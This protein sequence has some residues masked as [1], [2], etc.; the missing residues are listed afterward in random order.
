MSELLRVR[1]DLP[2]GFLSAEIEALQDLLGGPTLIH[3]KGRRDDTL[4][5]STLLHGNEDTGFKA[6]Q[7]LLQKH[8]LN[9]LPRN[10]SIFIGNVAAAKL[11]MR[12]LDGQP[13]Y[14]RVWP[15]AADGG[16]PE[17]ALMHAVVEHMR[18]RNL[19][20]SVDIHNN[21]GLNPHYAC[22]N[23][24]EQPF[25]HLATLFSRTVVYFLRPL[26]VQS[27]AF[28]PLCP[29]VTLECGKPGS[30]D[31][32]THAL[33]FLD[34]CLHLTALPTHA[35]AK[36]DLDLFHTVATVKVAEN[37]EF[38][39]G[40]GPGALRLDP[41]LDH[42]NFCELPPGTRFGQLA[43]D[44]LDCLEVRDEMGQAVGTRYFSAHQGELTTRRPIMP[45]ML[46]RDER[47]IRQDCLCYLMERLAYE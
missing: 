46:T 31:S 16:T 38:G 23:R 18:T 27:S 7:G 4:F 35:I 2:T 22:I 32:V 44:S 17:H 11:R 21:T 26:G 15:G 6:L 45:A 37:A 9:A 40:P 24:L 43:Q 8:D 1:T 28:A 5:V 33:S 47:V 30:A 12:R 41:A 3:L 14:N 29:A 13:D 34:A 42:M 19:F 10:L 36:H 39:F 20:A 25:Y